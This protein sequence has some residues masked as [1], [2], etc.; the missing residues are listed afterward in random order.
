MYP[1][2]RK[3]D[4]II[5]SSELCGICRVSFLSL[6][7]RLAIPIIFNKKVGIVTSIPTFF[8]LSFLSFFCYKS[9]YQYYT[10]TVKS[11]IIYEHIFIFYVLKAFFSILFMIEFQSDRRSSYA[12]F[13]FLDR[14]IRYQEKRKASASFITS[15]Q[16]Y[17]VCNSHTRSSLKCYYSKFFSAL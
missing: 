11:I 8:V 13:V 17:C 7:N 10:I 5:R 1:L 9:Q 12:L 4:I 6:F 2:G 15:V 16:Q 14:T 3:Y